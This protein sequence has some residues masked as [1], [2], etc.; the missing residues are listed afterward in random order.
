MRAAPFD[1]GSGPP[2]VVVQPLQGRWEWTKPLLVALSQRARVVSYSL[3]GDVGSGRLM[4]AAH[5]FEEFVGQLE[6][7][8][9]GSGIEAAALC[10]VSFGGAVAARFAAEFPHRVT[11]LIIASSPGPGWRP[12]ETQAKYVARPFLSMPAFTAGAVSRIGAEIGAALPTWPARLRFTARYAGA[13]VR[14]PMMPHLMASRVRLLERIDLAEDCARITAPTLVITGEPSL[15]RIVPVASTR[16]YADLIAGARYVMMDGTGH[17]GALTQ[18]SRFAALV[19][20]FI[21]GHDS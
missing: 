1:A 6:D 5:D 16:R 15:D 19:G 10:G 21:N 3:S 4:R 20:E 12:N 7:V 11:R 2:L 8:M 14:Y 13:A 9:D 17:L 18:P